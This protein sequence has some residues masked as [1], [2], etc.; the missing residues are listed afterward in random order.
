MSNI[1]DKKPLASIIIR[2]Y[3]PNKTVKFKYGEAQW[4]N[5]NRA[6][7]MQKI[8]AFKKVLCEWSSA[9]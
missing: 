6:C 1:N 9:K 5:K 8:K 4:I 3:I 2:N 7:F